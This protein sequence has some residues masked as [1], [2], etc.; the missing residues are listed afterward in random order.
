MSPP[1]RIRRPPD[2]LRGRVPPP[3]TLEDEP[4]LQL[5]IGREGIGLELSG[6]VSLGPV[7]LRDARARLVGLRFPLDV[8]GG[9][10]RFRHRRTALDGATLEIDPAAS[11]RWLASTAIGILGAGAADVRLAVATRARKPSELRLELSTDEAMVAFDLAIAG[12][13]A[14]LVAFAHRVRGLGGEVARTAVVG[15]F[16]HRLATALGGMA[17]G[18]RLTL[19]DPSRLAL[20][21]SFVPRGARLPSRDGV[22]VRGVDVAPD[23]LVLALARGETP[24]APPPVIAGLRELDRLVGDGDEALVRGDG[25]GARVWFL[26][27]LEQA[28]RHR[29]ILARLAEVDGERVEAALGWLREAQKTKGTTS[30]ERDDNELGR[31]LLAG[32][33]HARHDARTRARGAF[34]KGARAAYDDEEMRLA[35]RAF[36]RA[37]EACGPDDPQL[38]TLLDRALAADPAEPSARWARLRRSVRLGDDARAIE[39]VQHLEAQARGTEQR[40]RTLVRAAETWAAAGRVEHAVPAFER[41]LRYTPDDRAVVAGLGRSLLAAGEL[42]RGTSLLVQALELPGPA[43]GTIDVLL[44]LAAA[45]ADRA[46]DLSAAIARLRQIPAQAPR[47]PIARLRESTYRARLGDRVGAD[48]AL[49]DALEQCERRGL[50][51]VDVEEARVLLCDAAREVRDGGDHELARRS[52]LAALHLSPRDVEAETLVREL[53]RR[54]EP[55]GPPTDPPPRMSLALDESPMPPGVSATDEAR[56]EDLL[57]KVKIDPSNDAAVDELADLLSRLGRDFELYALLAARFEESPPEEQS[58]LAP[59]QRQVLERLATAAERNGRAM[60]A[61]LYRDAAKALPR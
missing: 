4:T 40:R 9:V 20:V 24:V 30:R 51:A 34:D 44:E 11:E 48:R 26:R 38:P 15:R 13:G 59:R 35:A 23:K 36:A 16:L 18:L 58:R 37:A 33:L 25:E 56:A 53:G 7:R 19:P 50:L 31:A 21:G 5:A 3:P 2:R 49:A 39:D 17:R 12:E 45:L 32:E 28:P 43:A 54:A 29:A 1:V 10:E 46:D 55:V 8:S 42:G 57:A 60:E 27:A 52:A 6:A 22:V 47:S 61:S 41:A 14:G